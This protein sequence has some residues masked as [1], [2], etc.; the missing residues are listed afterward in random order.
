MRR[1]EHMKVRT[2]ACSMAALTVVLVSPAAA[3]GYPSKPIRLIVPAPSG[4]ATDIRGRWIAG[5]L[6]RAL[7]QTIVVDNRGGAGGL[8]A[9]EAAAKSA[10]D[11]YTLALV[12]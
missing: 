2:T 8:L 4:S 7:G 1:E 11:G 5:L 6:T 9:T 10:P 3:Q 12:H